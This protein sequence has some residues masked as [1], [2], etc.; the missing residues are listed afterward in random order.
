[1]SHG[2]LQDDEHE[3]ALRFRLLGQGG[4]AGIPE[5]ATGEDLDRL[6]LIVIIAG[7]TAVGKSDAAMEL[8]E[9]LRSPAELISADSVQVYKGLD[10]GSN[11]PT[12]EEQERCTTHLID[13]V[14]PSS[15]GTAGH[16]TRDALRLIDELHAKATVPIV[17][18]GSCMYIDWLVHGEPDASKSDPEVHASIL[19]ELQPFE[20]AMDW[21]G[22]LALLA[23]VQ[24]E[25]AERMTRNNW[26]QLARQ[27][28]IARTPRKWTPAQRG[29]RSQF[30]LRCFFLSPTDRSALFHRIDSRCLAMMRKGLLEE[31]VELLASGALQPET[32]AGLAIGYR[33]VIDYLTRPE[34][35]DSDTQALGVFLRS[36]GTASRNYAAK[37]LHWFLRDPSFAWIAAN[38]TDPRAVATEIARLVALSPKAFRETA[39]QDATLRETQV[40]Q[41]PAMACFSSQLENL[42]ESALR[43]FLQLADACTRKVP[44]ALRKAS[45]PA[46]TLLELRGNCAT[47]FGK[48][49]W[50]GRHRRWGWG[51]PLGK[52]HKQGLH[53][54]ESC[55]WQCVKEDNETAVPVFCWPT[56]KAGDFPATCTEGQPLPLI[57]AFPQDFTI[58]LDDKAQL[59]AHLVAAGQG[60][61]HP[62]TWDAEEFL[63][64]GLWEDDASELWYLKHTQG[65]KGQS[66]YVFAGARAVE[67]RVQELGRQRKMFVVQRG[68]TPP[69]LRAG[70]RWVLRVH[71]LLRGLADGGLEA[72]CHRDVIRLEHGQPFTPNVDVKA[73]HVSSAGHQR[74][75]PKPEL[76][77][78]EGLEAQVFALAAKSFAAVWTH[79]PRGPYTPQDAELCQVFGL[80]MVADASGRLWLI[81]VNSYPAIAS[82]TMSHVDSGV[83]TSLVRDVLHLAVLP[84][85]EGVPAVLGGFVRLDVE[86]L[87]GSAPVATSA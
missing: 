28:E 43:P 63:Q 60:D 5:D 15:T 27:L 53:L 42:D 86:S 59:A 20:R 8:A 55:G 84:R 7:P 1:M 64:A 54:A 18:G 69:A 40:A 79:A 87:L 48:V 83:Y 33:Q 67:N 75:W 51:A 71:T 80:D 38:P 50:H 45:Q 12:R 47:P 3:T 14:E 22:A 2:N 65:V 56:R 74:H 62:P 16:W 85:I 30:D 21:E 10:V 4:G 34:P 57:R 36:F 29:A 82:G 52:L 41:G 17:V 77:S 13:C 76:L 32:Q 24:P 39:V 70:R 49:Y 61:V 19:Q 66:V 81:E 9:I 26:R 68:V 6:P 73:A 44:E 58:R 72:Y 78:D 31:V 46:P 37:Q 23:E 11:K 35:R 25:R